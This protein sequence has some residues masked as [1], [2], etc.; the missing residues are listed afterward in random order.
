[1]NSIKGFA[2]YCAYSAVVGAV[3][4]ALTSAW[5]PYILV[6]TGSLAGG[7]STPVVC[8]YLSTKPSVSKQI[9][10]ICLV[11]IMIL[12]N[13]TAFVGVSKL[14]GYSTTAIDA[15]IFGLQTSIIHTLGLA[16]LLHYN[17]L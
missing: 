8:A 16:A 15:S 14:L 4:G 9:D 2:E 7:L 5:T 3:S 13:T 6:E 11:A 10:S 17:L 12:S 1:M